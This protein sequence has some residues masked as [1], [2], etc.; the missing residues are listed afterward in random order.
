MDIALGSSCTGQ[1]CYF[2]RLSQN[3]N[4]DTW[5]YQVPFTYSDPTTSLCCCQA[6]PMPSPP[7]PPLPATASTFLGSTSTLPT[8]RRPS[9]AAVPPH[10]QAASLAQHTQATTAT[11]R[12][13]MA[14]SARLFRSSHDY[15]L[16]VM[17]AKSL[18]VEGT[19]GMEFLLMRLSYN[20]YYSTQLQAYSAAG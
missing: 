13:A 3:E 5:Q 11:H 7:Q 20:G 15:L 9:S 6:P 19:A 10:P 12:S 1:A 8:F 16:R 17:S 18:K 14:D 4:L 2:R